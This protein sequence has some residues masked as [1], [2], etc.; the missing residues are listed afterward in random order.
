VFP[1]TEDAALRPMNVYA[2][3]KVAAEGSVA[4]AQKSGMSAA[5]LRFASV[6]GDVYDHSD[7][8]IPA[9]LQA[10]VTG[11]TLRV[12]GSRNGFDFTHVK[13]LAD[14]ITMAAALMADRETSL[15]PLHF[16]SGDCIRL[17]ELAAMAVEVGGNSSARII[18][19]PARNFN[20][21]MFLG[22]PARANAMLGWRAQTP[23]ALGLV[24]LAAEYRNS[25]ASR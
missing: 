11:G 2:R 22:D 13:D 9:F 6:Y 8:V 25:P 12:E 4:A 3:S 19:A 23:L 7:R 24:Q 20:V 18:E 10:A 17:D 5:I 16:V 15:P 14:G 1:V 21:Q